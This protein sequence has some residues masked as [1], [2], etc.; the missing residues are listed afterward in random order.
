MALPKD[1]AVRQQALDICQSFAV[2]APAGSGKTGLLTQRVLALLGACEQPE[3]VLAITFTK[4]AAAEMQSRI[5]SA[6]HDVQEKIQHHSPPPEEAHARVTWDLAIKVLQ[7]NEEKQWQLLS[8]PNRLRI[9]T[10]DSFCRQ[11][12]QQMPLSNSLGHTPEVLDS[13][14]VEYAYQL[15]TRETLTLLEKNHP[16][17]DDLITLVQHFNN[18]LTTLENL[19]IQLLKRRDQWL[20]PLYSSK[21]QRQNLESILQSVINSHLQQLKESL[22]PLSGELIS[23]AD[24]AATMLNKESK[25]SDISVCAGIEELPPAQYTA[26]NQWMG[27]VE[28][29]TTKTGNI[30]GTIDKRW[31]FPAPD[32]NM[33]KEEKAFTKEQKQRML[34][35]LK[36]ISSLNNTKDL[37]HSTRGLPS[38]AY[39]DQQWNLLDSL[40]R[41][42][43]LLCAQLRIIFQQLGKTDFIDITLAALNA[44]GGDERPTDLAL[45]LDYQI[46]HILVDEFQDTSTPQLQLL[47]KLTAGWQFDDGRTLFVVGDAMQSCYGFRDANVGIFLDIRKNGLG[48]IDLI[49]L[50]LTVNFRSQKK[51]VDWCND[52][53]ENI[54]PKHNAINKGA[55]KY[56]HAIA[57]NSANDEQAVTTHLFVSNEKIKQRSHEANKIA[58]VIQDTQNQNPDGSIAILVRKRGQVN[59][60]TKALNQTNITYRATEIDRLNTSMVIIDLLTLTRSLLYPNDRIAWLSLLR[61]PWCGLDMEDLYKIANAHIERKNS[62]LFSLIAKNRSNLSLSKNGRIL[63]DRFISTIQHSLQNQGRYSLRQ[64]IEATWLQLGG[65]ALL[66]NEKDYS[67]VNAFLQLLEKHQQGW[68]LPHWDTFKNA[69]NQL[70][71][72]AAFDDTTKNS[73]K[74]AVEIMTIHKAKGLEFDT[75]IIPGLD[76][77]SASDKQE[78]LAWLEVLDNQ[79]KS[80]LVISP[81]HA[82]GNERDL[83]HDYIR[84]QQ[85]QKQSLESDRLFYV[86]CTR[87]INQLHL[88]AYHTQEWEGKKSEYNEGQVNQP[89]KSSLTAPKRNTSLSNIWP[90]IIENVLLYPITEI[91]KTDN[92]ERPKHPSRI[93]RLS[94]DWQRPN[95]E[96]DDLLKK[97]RLQH[98]NE[99]VVSDN[100]ARPDELK[101]RHARYFGTILHNALQQ[102]T[103]TGHQHW[104]QA[105]IKNQEAFW[106]KQLEQMGTPKSLSIEQSHK[107]SL[108]VDKMLKSKVGNWLLDHQHPSSSC[109]LT[110]WSNRYKQLKELIIDR[111][112]IDAK[113][114]TRWIVD[115]KSSEPDH[116]QNIDEFVTQEAEIY[117]QQLANYRELFKNHSEPIRTALYFPLLDIFHEIKF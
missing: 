32:K 23:L 26:I 93:S 80:Q 4:K 40:T 107:I 24:Y 99:T 30:R 47:K 35:L 64:W 88:L 60:I 108:S 103:E 25:L 41:V 114:N 115:Y 63:L 74:P 104:N 38:P 82:T 31:G 81:V 53:F 86:G 34:T 112:F 39:T 3:N 51:L 18:Q 13:A 58:E 72:D 49:P 91:N 61:G 21:D 62:I 65:K 75:V 69:V 20:G 92:Q 8:L 96:S 42:L 78:L 76:L 89:L 68:R 17:Q 54:F 46:Q 70:Y 110:L 113:D 98:Y 33:S 19:F 87:A 10:I 48:N 90:Y 105:R 1:S 28:L 73:A 43:T 94:I 56:Q 83:V 6:L 55:V 106:Q 85:K 52:I 29:L 100:R 66:K 101:R 11:I 116:N 97:Y 5:L 36:E 57:F 9:T 7:R 37:L 15:A 45:K 2:S 79:Q 12:S 77:S 95:Y 102:I 44:L 50:D 14:E 59:E 67:T 27:L 117:K 84:E 111:T 71:A 16:L 109:E 22:K